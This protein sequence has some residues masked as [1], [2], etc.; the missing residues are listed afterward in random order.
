MYIERDKSSICEHSTD[1]DESIEC[2]ESYICKHS[3][4]CNKYKEWK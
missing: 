4:E 2:G 1:W 3:R